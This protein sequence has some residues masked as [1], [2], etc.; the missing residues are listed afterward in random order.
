MA[1]AGGDEFWLASYLPSDEL[2]EILSRAAEQILEK[3]PDYMKVT[4]QFPI[5]YGVCELQ[6]YSSL[7]DALRAADL[8]MYKM[9]NGFWVEDNIIER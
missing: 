7:D 4:S 9:K 3:F 5:S 6:G 1:R 2:R 8:E